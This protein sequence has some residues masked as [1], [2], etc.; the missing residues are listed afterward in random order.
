MAKSPKNGVD[1]SRL[2]RREVQ[3]LNALRRSLGQQ[4]A[5]KAFLEWRQYADTRPEAVADKNIGVISDAL[6][7]IIE[8]HKLTLPRSGYLLRRSRGRVIVT[9][10]ADN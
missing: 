6:E 5:D 7:Q 3:R 8:H 4:T 2:S 10:A 1:V 9:R